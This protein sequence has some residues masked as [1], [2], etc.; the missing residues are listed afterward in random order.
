[1]LHII[2]F[3]HESSTMLCYDIPE[4]SR[5]NHVQLSLIRASFNLYLLSN[6][7]QTLHV[8]CVVN[9]KQEQ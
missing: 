7:H 8:N 5:P 9:T 6:E 4:V 2:T 1:M 3:E